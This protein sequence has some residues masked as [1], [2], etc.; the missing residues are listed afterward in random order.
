MVRKIDSDV[1][2]VVSVGVFFAAAGVQVFLTP[3]HISFGVYSG[4][5][6]GFKIKVCQQEHSKSSDFNDIKITYRSNFY[7]L[8][9][10]A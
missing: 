8:S 5:Y 1:V 7:V 4:T 9:E 10:K 6:L 2:G 3:G